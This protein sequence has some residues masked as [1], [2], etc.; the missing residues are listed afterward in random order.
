LGGGVDKGETSLDQKGSA[1]RSTGGKRD[2]KM[3]RVRVKSDCD[4]EDKGTKKTPYRDPRVIAG[5]Q[6]DFDVKG[7][8]L[9]RRR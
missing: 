7:R 8:T 9:P 3:H 6:V 4:L 5:L 1:T 2:V